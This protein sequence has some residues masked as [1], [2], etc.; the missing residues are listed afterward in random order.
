MSP[1]FFCA[2]HAR[3]KNRCRI[4]ARISVRIFNRSD[5]KRR[6]RPTAPR[7]GEMRWLVRFAARIVGLVVLAAVWTL[8]DVLRYAVRLLCWT[9][10]RYGW[11]PTG[12]FLGAF[13][14]SV[15]IH[16]QAER[17]SFTGASVGSVALATLVLWGGMVGASAWLVQAWRRRT[18][19][20]ASPATPM[21]LLQA[22]SVALPTPPSVLPT[23]TAAETVHLGPAGPVQNGAVAVDSLRQAWQR[24]LARAG[25]PGPDGVTV[26][27]FS[28]DSETY[29]HQLA[30]DL[31]DGNYRPLPPRWVEIPKPAGR[32]RRLAILCVRDRIVQ[33]ALHLALGPLWDARFAP[34]S[35]AYR[36]RRSALD[37]VAGVEKALAV[38]RVWVAD[39]DIASFFDS[40]PHPQLFAF[41]S[42]WL[43]DPPMHRLVQTCVS[44]FSPEPGRGLAQGAP[45]SPLMA[46]L[47][48]DRFDTAL[49]GAGHD[50]VRYSD[51]FL[52]LGATR[53]HA[54]SGLQMAE[55]LLQGLHLSLNRDK[56]RIVHRDEGFTFLGYHF[57]REGKRPSAEAVGSLKARMAATPEEET[58]RRIVTGWQGYFG[59]P[60][61][62][63]SSPQ[64]STPV[65]APAA[66]PDYETEAGSMSP[67]KPVG[68]SALTMFRER[69]VGR[70]DVFARHWQKEGR[71]GYAAV[72]RAVTD[73]ELGRHL[74]GEAV[75]G[76]YLL[77]ADGTT[78]ELVLDIDGPA[79][80][81]A[82]QRK[83][84]EVAQ[85]LTVTLRSADVAPIWLDSGGKGYHLWFCFQ[86]PTPARPLRRWAARWLDNFRPLPEGVLVEVFPKQDGVVVGG[87]GSLIR[88]PL[89]RH[90]ITGRRSV[91]LTPEGR[92]LDAWAALAAAPWISPGSLLKTDGVTSSHLPEPPQEIACVIE[93]CSILASLLAKAARTRALRHSERLALLY[94]LGHGGEAGRTYLHQ[95][96]ALC[97][98]YEPRITERWLRR[99]QGG[100]KPVRCTTLQEWLKDALPAVKCGCGLKRAT[101]SPLDFLRPSKAGPPVPAPATSERDHHGWD[102]VAQDLFGDAGATEDTEEGEVRG[103]GMEN[104]GG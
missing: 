58:R 65:A 59:V 71:S 24:I 5:W 47:Y 86:E 48:L 22:N 7:D 85:R 76:T 51:D 87:L 46:N 20:H 32:T 99:A 42:E 88:L 4:W 67:T 64:S 25:G 63:D 19:M 74:G 97:A 39:G 16:Q 31:R 57:G 26:E 94:T 13:W 52:I 41:M 21:T 9:V 69:F 68:S 11:G 29:L 93:G 72:H 75:L 45:L 50:L 40:V 1:G 23:R 3:T 49:S 98:N 83:A 60:A 17:L 38:G 2:G 61:L 70:P 102:H 100:R 43:P 33:Q 96:M 6:D 91:L 36:P 18:V 84:F 44:A 27:T 28:L 90:P 14:I 10:R 92:P 81:E 78:K 35:Y 54:E 56:T 95:I 101:R 80:D 66:E 79:T 8:C 53:Q 15:W 103:D 30:A 37:A 104:E 55:R 34:C 12:R 73:E 77:H 89:G 82:G 62:S